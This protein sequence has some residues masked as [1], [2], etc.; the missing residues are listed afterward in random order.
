MQPAQEQPGGG[1]VA[2]MDLRDGGLL[3]AAS[4]PRFNPNVF[5]S[6]GDAARR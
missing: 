2:V 1:A 6:A 3:A 5:T 4:A